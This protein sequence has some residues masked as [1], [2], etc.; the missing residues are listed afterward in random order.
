MHR[1]RRYLVAAG[2]ALSLTG[3]VRRATLTVLDV[4]DV[5]IP[6]PRLLVR[7]IPAGSEVDAAVQGLTEVLG[8]CLDGCDGAVE[9]R[10]LRYEEELGGWAEGDEWAAVRIARVRFDVALLDAAGA[11]LEVLRDVGALDRWTARGGSEGE[12]QGRLGAADGLAVDL[13]YSAGVAYAHRLKSGSWSFTRSYYAGGPLRYGAAALRD[14]DAEG[15]MAEWRRV[16]R[17]AASPVLVARVHHD[18]AVACEWIGASA[19][20]R[21]HLQLA[22]AAGA[23]A[24]TRRYADLL[25]TARGRARPLRQ[26]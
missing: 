1:L 20:A 2:C 13:A 7:A 15:A 19:L 5:E 4:A 9:I 24:R 25:E 10:A 26:F 6:G 3:C 21:D 8:V 11:E 22:L 18:L 23:S 14:G 17:D 12:A 16:A